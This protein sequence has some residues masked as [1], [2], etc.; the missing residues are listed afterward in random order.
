VELVTELRINQNLN[1]ILLQYLHQNWDK[2]RSKVD[3]KLLQQTLRSFSITND[4]L[5]AQGKI[6]WKVI[7]NVKKYLLRVRVRVFNATFNNISVISWWSV[8]LVE[9]TTDLS[10]VTDKLSVVST[11]PR[12]EWDS[13]SQL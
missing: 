3:K 7:E 9:K 1:S 13:K 11:T 12:H 8:L 5:S 2:L 4:E 6:A 10:Q